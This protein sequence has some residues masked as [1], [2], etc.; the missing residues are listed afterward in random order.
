MPEITPVFCLCNIDHYTG[1]CYIFYRRAAF[2]KFLLEVAN[3]LSLEM[4]LLLWADS[5]D[6]VRDTVC[7]PRPNHSICPGVRVL[8]FFFLERN[9]RVLPDIN[10]FQ[11]K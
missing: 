9:F 3:K 8:F 4:A 10:I 1:I 2:C 7:T 6:R 11:N 5:A